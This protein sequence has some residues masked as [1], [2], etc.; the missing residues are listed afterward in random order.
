MKPNEFKPMDTDDTIYILDGISLKD[1]INT[2]KSKW[3]V[4]DMKYI[5][6]ESEY[7]HTRCLS[8]D[9]YDCSDYDEYLVITYN[10]N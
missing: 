8:Y 9:L 5:D 2:V 7:I 10:P 1:L 6:I 4:V 3:G